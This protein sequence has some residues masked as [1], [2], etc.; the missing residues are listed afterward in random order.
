[1]STDVIKE[2]VEALRDPEDK[3]L[4]KKIFERF[5]EDKNGQLTK[6]EFLL[7][8]SAFGK[9]VKGDEFKEDEKFKQWAES[10][11]DSSD[12]DKSG[13]ITFDEFHQFLIDV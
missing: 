2:L 7:F 3:D 9:S 13:A 8:M 10:S 4:A 11:F 5:D 6:S 1:M 12:T